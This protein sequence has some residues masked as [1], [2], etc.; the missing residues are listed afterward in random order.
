[1][2]LNRLI[3]TWFGSGLSPKAPGTVGTL[4]ALPFAFFIQHFLGVEALAISA[5]LLFPFGCWACT[6]YIREHH[7]EDPSE[8]V[9]DEVVAMWLVLAFMPQTIIGYLIGFALFRAFDIVKPWPISWADS[10]IKGGI[11]VMLDDVLAVP[12]VLLIYYGFI[13]YVQPFVAL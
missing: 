1:M 7:R 11:G 4:A 6:A 12:C 13:Y 5:L 3:G 10:N 8:L 2:D 9:V